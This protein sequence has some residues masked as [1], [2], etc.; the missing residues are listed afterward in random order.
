MITFVLSAMTSHLLGVRELKR[1]QHYRF[2]FFDRWGGSRVSPFL[3][4]DF[5]FY[6]S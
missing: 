5:G 4:L 3:S 1:L 2:R 6:G